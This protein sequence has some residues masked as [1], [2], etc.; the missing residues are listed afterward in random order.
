[1]ASTLLAHRTSRTLFERHN[2]ATVGLPSF[3]S[4]MRLTLEPEASADAHYSLFDRH[5]TNWP[6]HLSYPPAFPVAQS[7]FAVLREL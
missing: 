1:M 3:F 4:L 6:L 7:V 5:F 2:G